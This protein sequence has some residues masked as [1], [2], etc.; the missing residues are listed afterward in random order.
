MYYFILYCT[1]FYL[2]ILFLFII[3][4]FYYYYFYLFC[5]V[6]KINILYTILI[7]GFFVQAIY[8]E[9]IYLIIISC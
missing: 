9:F 2:F 4:Y 7:M 8:D 6:L 5:V 3:F 1:F